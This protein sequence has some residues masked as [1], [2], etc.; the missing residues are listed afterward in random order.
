[1]AR[2]SG[3]RFALS[4]AI[5]LGAYAKIGDF[6]VDEVFMQPQDLADLREGARLRGAKGL[7]DC[8]TAC[9]LDCSVVSA[10]CRYR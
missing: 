2:L 5:H 6:A 10:C 9:F 3:D 1:M 8:L 7:Q 4:D